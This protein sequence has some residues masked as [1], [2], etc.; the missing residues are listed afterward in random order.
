VARLYPKRK[1]AAWG[2]RHA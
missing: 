1:P 2:V